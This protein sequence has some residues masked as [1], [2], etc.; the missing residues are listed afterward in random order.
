MIRLKNSKIICLAFITLFTFSN[1]ILAKA[2]IT[3]VAAENV[4]GSIAK[5]LGGPYVT[6]TSI[7][8][9]PAQDPHLFSIRPSVS[10][11]IADADMVIYNGADYD[12]WMN[13]LL[14]IKSQKQRQVVVV[15]Q[16][17]H[18][19]T[20]SNPHIWY[21]PE[22]IPLFAQY[23]V[24][25]LSQDDPIHQNDYTHQLN[26]FKNEYQIIF[27]TIKRLKQ[28]FQNTPVIATEPLFGYMAKSIG[29]NMHGEGFQT[30]I[31]NDVPPTISQIKQFEDDLK[32][33]TVRV[34]I[35]NNQVVNPLTKHMLSIAHKEKIPVLG[36]SEMMPANMTYVEWMM[37]QLTELEKALE[38]QRVQS[39]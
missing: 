21:I 23:L 26:H 20:G 5:Q 2:A 29:L 7:L 24:S 1:A 4:Y 12:P 37:K 30:S 19:K 27:V 17:V 35:Y 10:K 36:V 28:R 31:M 13:T 39:S 14:A 8:N 38:N 15:S 32:Q 33:H 3:I 22:T 9:N 6:V 34:L 18:I 25:I 11:A 16:L